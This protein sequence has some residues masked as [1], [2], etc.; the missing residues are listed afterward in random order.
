M[1]MFF[2]QQTEGV[3]TNRFYERIILNRERYVHSNSYF[4]YRAGR[5]GTRFKKGNK[6]DVVC[7]PCRLAFGL[8]VRL[9][10]SASRNWL[11]W[12]AAIDLSK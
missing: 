12:V 1:D 6:G 11:A 3:E 10:L 9:K 8:A 4:M 7:Y 5:F 2:I